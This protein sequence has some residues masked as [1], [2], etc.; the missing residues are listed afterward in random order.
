M[1]VFYDFDT[2]GVRRFVETDIINGLE[3]VRYT[4]TDLEYINVS[5]AIVRSGWL[6]MGLAL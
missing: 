4:A 5:L 3:V 1:I 2:I 6:T